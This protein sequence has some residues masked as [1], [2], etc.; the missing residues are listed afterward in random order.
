MS[1]EH[2]KKGDIFRVGDTIRRVV[3]GTGGTDPHRRILIE[4][5]RPNKRRIRCRVCVWQSWASKGEPCGPRG[6]KLKS[7]PSS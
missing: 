4:E 1:L 6:G 7:P 5:L 2:P 3:R